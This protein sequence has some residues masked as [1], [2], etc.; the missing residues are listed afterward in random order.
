M[1][2]RRYW[3]HKWVV[4]IGGNPDLKEGPEEELEEEK[5]KEDLSP[6]TERMPSP[7]PKRRLGFWSR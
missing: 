3:N 7:P 1:K 5:Q 2:Q 4:K 6:N